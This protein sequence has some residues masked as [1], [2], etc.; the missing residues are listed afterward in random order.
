MDG[1]RDLWMT[2]LIVKRVFSVVR[3]N[4]LL[5][6]GWLS[7]LDDCDILMGWFRVIWVTWLI[8]MVDSSGLQ[9]TF[10]IAIIGYGVTGV[11]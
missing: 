7:I 3:T 4:I 11:S 8:I 10:M 2:C 5:I 1:S 6:I 9:M